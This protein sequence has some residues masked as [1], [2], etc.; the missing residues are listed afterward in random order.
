MNSASK[1][2]N[3]RSSNID[4]ATHRPAFKEISVE[5]LVLAEEERN[6]LPPENFRHDRRTP[7]SG[8]EVERKWKRPSL[9]YSVRRHS[10]QVFSE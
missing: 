3:R 1:H 6:P 10:V 4:R 8:V 2:V 9:R 7:Q 5:M